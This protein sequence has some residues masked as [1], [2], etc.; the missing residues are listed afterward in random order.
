MIFK[1]Y[2]YTTKERALEAVKKNGCELKFAS[3]ELQ[4]DPDVVLAAVTQTG[5]ALYYASDRLKNK[6]EIVLAAIRKNPEALKYASDKL[7]G[8]VEICLE[9][10]KRHPWSFLFASKEFLC[11]P[12]K[13]LKAV[14]VDYGA[15]NEADIALTSDPD[16]MLKAIRI[17]GY[18]FE[19]ASPELLEDVDLRILSQYRKAEFEFDMVVK[20]LNLTRA[21]VF[22]TF[23]DITKD[24][25]TDYVKEMKKNLGAEGLSAEQLKQLQ[26]ELDKMI[27]TISQ[28]RERQVNLQK[29]HADE[30][31][32]ELDGVLDGFD[33]T[34]TSE[35]E[36]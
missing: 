3:P 29:K 8:D 30:K 25:V 24:S 34:K 31:L 7:R 10:L 17:N 14:E 19:Y 15:L 12:E 35:I 33:L 20:T 27:K 21:D 11:N 5:Y 22:N 13:M 28:A 32:A 2:K 9:V 4:N 26:E 18:S 23:V 36:R 1:K 16:F 6:R